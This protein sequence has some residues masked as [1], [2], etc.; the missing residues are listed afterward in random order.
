M[1][2]LIFVLAETLIITF[3]IGHRQSCP[4][5]EQGHKAI[6]IRFN[7][8][9]QRHHFL[10]YGN[11]HSHSQSGTSMAY[12]SVSQQFSGESQILPS[13][14]GNQ[15]LKELVI[16]EIPT[17]GHGQDDPNEQAWDQ[18]SAFAV[19]RVIGFFKG[20]FIKGSRVCANG[21]MLIELSVCSKFLASLFCDILK[22]F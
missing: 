7:R 3:G 21:V 11:K 14:V 20:F 10:E 16:V 19:T 12:G 17:E 22:T 8:G 1:A 5:E 4:V 18:K 13:K 9:N 2:F 6:K 15:P